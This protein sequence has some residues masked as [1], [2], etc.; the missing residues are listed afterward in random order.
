MI[1]NKNINKK[2]YWVNFFTWN[3]ILAFIFCL[4]TFPVIVFIFYD[5]KGGIWFYSFQYLTD[6]G[7]LIFWTFLAL[8][9]FLHNRR[10]F[11]KNYFLICAL[12]YITFVFIG[13][14][15]LL[16]PGDIRNAEF[17]SI[18]DWVGTVWFHMFSPLC[19]FIFGALIIAK[20]KHGTP[21]SKVI[22]YGL[23]YIA[24]QFVYFT[25]LPFIS[26]KIR[27][28]N[29]LNI[30]NYLGLSDPNQYVGGVS[31]FL[32][33]Y[34]NG[35]KNSIIKISN[36][37]LNSYK[38]NKQTLAEHM[39]QKWFSVNN[40]EYVK[41]NGNSLV[42]NKMPNTTQLAHI[43]HNLGIGYGAIK[44]IYSNNLTYFSPNYFSVY[45]NITN[46]NSNVHLYSINYINNPKYL[47]NIITSLLSKSNTFNNWD[48]LY[49]YTPG[50]WWV[51]GIVFGAFFAYLIFLTFWW[52]MCKLGQR[53][54]INKIIITK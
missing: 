35:S 14:N 33:F 28:N 53:N 21:S 44:D 13:F 39:I 18:K 15:T 25:S 42:L 38:G 43:Y 47:H 19:D 17:V 40:V 34:N 4:L 51:F 49:G 10:I 9:A 20:M 2:G 37:I 54:K 8:Y 1:I 32:Q 6:Q 26:A 31:H 41:W 29:K 27:F 24:Y 50:G 12:A 45:G 30:Y 23:I 3:R 36:Q 52:G 16:L 7:N 11:N 46:L 5:I 48:N 22:G